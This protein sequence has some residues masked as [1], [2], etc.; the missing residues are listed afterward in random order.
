MC[1]LT[2]CR[3]RPPA[4]RSCAVCSAGSDKL[5]FAR[6]LTETGPSEK[7]QAD[8]EI[9]FNFNAGLLVYRAH[10]VATHE[11]I[12]LIVVLSGESY[13]VGCRCVHTNLYAV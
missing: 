11:S 6:R 4:Q 2:Q 5:C 13:G 9:G 8:P 12:D 10:D 7:W 1:R 3:Y